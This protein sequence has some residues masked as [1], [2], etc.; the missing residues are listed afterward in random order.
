MSLTNNELNREIELETLIQKS[1]PEEIKDKLG[2]SGIVQLKTKV[3]TEYFAEKGK[4]M[5]KPLLFYSEIKNFLKNKG[6]TNDQRKKLASILKQKLNQATH[7]ENN[8]SSPN[9]NNNPVSS[10]PT[11]PTGSVANSQGNVVA[12]PM[13]STPP[14]K[15]GLPPAS[16]RKGA[17]PPT[18]SVVNSQMPSTSP[19]GEKRPN[20]PLSSRKGA[21]SSRFAKMTFLQNNLEAKNP[22]Q[23]FIDLANLYEIQMESQGKFKNFTRNNMKKISE[24]IDQV[25]EM[26]AY[27]MLDAKNSG[28]LND[29]QT[30]ITNISQKIERMQEG[31][32]KE[33]FRKARDTFRDLFQADK[34]VREGGKRTRKSK[35]RKTRK[36]RGTRRH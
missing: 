26:I 25:L 4:L 18:S 9:N 19:I 7:K 31:T 6:V 21:T 33:S 35:A 16:Q 15:R 30:F 17:T 24:R 28:E 14:P 1:I 2:P 11:T 12:P 27:L 5:P 23:L 34:N 32:T 13:S 22:A 3:L 8:T 36:R 10:V 20:P 29:V